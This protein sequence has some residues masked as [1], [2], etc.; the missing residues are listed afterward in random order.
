MLGMLELRLN[1]LIENYSRVDSKRHRFRWAQSN[2]LGDWLFHVN[3]FAIGVFGIRI[4][5]PIPIGL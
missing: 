5:F 2:F 4:L 3:F 1:I